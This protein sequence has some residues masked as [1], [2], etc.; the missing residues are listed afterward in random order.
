MGSSCP[1]SSRTAFVVAAALLVLGSNARPVRA[2][3]RFAE[4]AAN[5]GEIHTGLPLTHRFTFVNEGPEAVEITEVRPGCGCLIPRPGQ[6]IYQPGEHGSLPVEVNTLSQPAGPHTWHLQVSYRNGTRANEV[7]L[8]ITARLMSEITVQPAELIIVADRAVEH[9]ILV[10]DFRPRPLTVVAVRSTSPHLTA[11]ITGQARDA[12]GHAV[13]KIRLRLADDYP[14][15]RHEEFLTVYT[16]DPKYRELK[17]KA[18]ITMQA[19]RRVTALPDRVALTADP[20]APLPSRLVRLRDQKGEAVLVDRLAADDPAI[21]CRWA[22]GPESMATVRIAVDQ[23]R[24]A[25]GR[26]HSAVHVFLRGP[27]PE[28]VTIPVEA[29]PK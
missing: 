13:C 26:L 25:G 20:G 18:I 23:T 14:E 15:G 1:R 22:P 7:A 6:R 8:Q 2:D 17:V 4:P 10:T 27:V 19:R 11:D 3:L 21:T 5:L 12:Q 29:G 28:E 9:E 24:L 16:A